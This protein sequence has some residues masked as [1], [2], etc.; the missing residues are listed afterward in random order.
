MPREHDFQLR[1]FHSP[2]G[3]PHVYV[4]HSE[5]RLLAFNLEGAK[6]IEVDYKGGGWKALFGDI[7]SKA[8]CRQS[9]SLQALYENL[10]DLT[11]KRP[12]VVFITGV[13]RLLI[14]VGPGLL[15]AMAHW[16]AFVRHGSGLSSMYLV[17]D[18]GPRELTDATFRPRTP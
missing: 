4:V 16:E 14:D 18:V 2:A 6:V 3:E 1:R 8:E 7:A 10:E 9:S 13:E 11:D 5:D 15:A 17:L 12:L